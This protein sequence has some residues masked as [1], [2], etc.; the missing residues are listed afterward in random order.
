VDPLKEEKEGL[1][2]AKIK[3]KISVTPSKFSKA[4]KLY[5]L[6]REERGDLRVA[7]TR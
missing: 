6:A 4:P 2:V 5:R 3:L 7:K 1:R